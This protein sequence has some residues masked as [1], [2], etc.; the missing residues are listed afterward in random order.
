MCFDF[1]RGLFRSNQ[2]LLQTKKVQVQQVAP[3][4]K[5][6]LQGFSNTVKRRFA[7]VMGMDRTP[8]RGKLAQS[9]FP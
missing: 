9:C 2:L 1:R 6:A 4:D 3:A 5:K 8:A 7:F